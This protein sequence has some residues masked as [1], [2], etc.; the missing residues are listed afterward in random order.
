MARGIPSKKIV[1][2]S[3]SL[4]CQFGKN[5]CPFEQRGLSVPK[6]CHPFEWLGLSVWKK[7]SSLRTAWDI[8]FKKLLSVRTA[9]VIRLKKKLLTIGGTEPICSKI[10][11]K[12]HPKTI[13]SLPTRVE[14]SVILQVSYVMKF[15]YKPI[16]SIYGSLLL[17]SHRRFHITNRLLT[18]LTYTVVHILFNT[19][20][21]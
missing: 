2:H 12:F 19:G 15:V 10:L 7:L 13:S 17:C 1:I 3:N 20:C 21:Y 6:K 11:A 9:R 16:M 4:G 18:V 8:R 14:R 5:C